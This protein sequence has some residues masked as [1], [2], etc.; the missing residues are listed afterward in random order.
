MHL[1]LPIPLRRC[2]LGSTRDRSELLGIVSD[3][4]VQPCACQQVG[5]R[6]AAAFSAASSD[7]EED[8]TWKVLALQV[9][10]LAWQQ[11]RQRV[12]AAIWGASEEEDDNDDDFHVGQGVA[13]T[14]SEVLALQVHPLAWQQVGQRVA[15]AIWA[16]SEEDDDN[17]D[18]FHVGQGVAATCSAVIEEVSDDDDFRAPALTVELVAWQQVG[19]RIAAA[20]SAV[21]EDEDGEFGLAFLANEREHNTTCSSSNRASPAPTAASI[22]TA[23]GSMEL[24]DVSFSDGSCSDEEQ[25]N[26]RHSSQVRFSGHEFAAPAFLSLLEAKKSSALCTQVAWR[27]SPAEHYR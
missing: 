4:H 22:S 25:D 13:A 16:A 14:C 5:Q 24:C 23:P 2:V 15:A 7:D 18:D 27:D 21:A 9:H 19:Q 6:I 11:V 1:I 26:D 8:E 20:I 3:A 17:D 10:P 12:A